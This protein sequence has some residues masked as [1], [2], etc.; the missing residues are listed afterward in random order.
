MQVNIIDLGIWLALPI[1]DSLLDI[2]FELPDA[3]SPMDLGISND[4]RNLGIAIQSIIVSE[5][6]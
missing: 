2:R 4:T 5:Q 6:K 3:V 1:T